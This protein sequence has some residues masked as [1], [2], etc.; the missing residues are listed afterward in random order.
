MPVSN[1]KSLK[2]AK[3]LLN[4]LEHLFE[5]YTEEQNRNSSVPWAGIR[6]TMGQCRELLNE[7]EFEESSKEANVDLNIEEERLNQN[8]NPE[9][10]NSERPLPLSQRIQKI[11]GVSSRVR[12]LVGNSL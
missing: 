4:M 6:L 12:E 3:D 5:K 11:P 9:V 1:E 10:Y 2:D 8:K 7:I